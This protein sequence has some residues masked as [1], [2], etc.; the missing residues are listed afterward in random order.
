MARHATFAALF[1][2]AAALATAPVVPAAHAAQAGLGAA[3]SGA[4][5]TAESVL[6][7]LQSMPTLKRHVVV[8]EPLVRIGDLV[9]NAGGLA[10]VPIFR[11]PDVGTSGAVPTAQVVEALRRYHMMTL[12]VGDIAEVEVT[13]AG[14]IVTAEA[15]RDRILHAFAGRYGLGKAED[16]TLVVERDIRPFAV[17]PTATAEPGVSRASY[18]VRTGRFDITLDIPGSAVARRLP[19]RFTGTL[20]EL[21]ETLVLAR[22]IQR[23]EVV[24]T[25]DVTVER[26]PKSEV[27]MDAAPTDA[28]VIGLA[29]RQ[30][31]RAGQSLRLADLTKPDLVKRDDTV[32]I[33]YRAPGLLLTTRGRAL[34]SGAEGDLVSAMNLQSKR[35]VQGVVTGTGQITLTS[36]TT[37]LLAAADTA[38]RAL[39]ETATAAAASSIRQ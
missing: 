29:A 16:L 10:E 8:S 26:R 31:L 14:R 34:E 11:A 33:V 28:R 37:H 32:T 22:S 9:D 19:L 17:E 2:L 25:S 12:D 30:T 23:G 6:A 38:P 20:H 1:G 18:D 5:A 3:G 4:P 21:V 36:T 27:P 7:S 15:I 35:T 39:P 13:R 24:R